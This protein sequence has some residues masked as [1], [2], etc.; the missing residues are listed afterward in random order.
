MADTK[1]RVFTTAINL[2]AEKGYAN[3]GIRD[4]ADTVGIKSA[5]IY[6]HFE[7]KDAILERIYLF[8][9][10]TYIASRPKLEDVLAQIP[11]ISAY[12]ALDWLFSST[13]RGGSTYELLKRAGLI[14]TQER[15]HD[16]RAD[17]LISKVFADA[18][19]RISAVLDKMLELDLIEPINVALFSHIF[20]AFSLSATSCNSDQ[21][22][23]S[24]DD[25]RAGRQ[26]LFDLIRTK[27][28]ARHC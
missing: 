24:Y 16:Q 14:A 17:D 9:F 4:I 19:A 5:S 20:I 23:L 15:G 12:E 25:W 13:V 11:G 18:N 28:H 27:E 6:N 1:W 10:D 21:R 2:F 7:N 8:F 26:L 22:I 3:I